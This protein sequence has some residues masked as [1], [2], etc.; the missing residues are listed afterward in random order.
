MDVLAEITNA[1]N[2]STETRPENLESENLRSNKLETDPKKPINVIFVDDEHHVLD[3]L[4]RS[5]HLKG[6]VG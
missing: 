4:K 1:N 5:L 3:G 2:L 6:N